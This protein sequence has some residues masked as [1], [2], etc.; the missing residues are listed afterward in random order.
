MKTLRR[1][2]CMHVCYVR[3]HAQ[4]AYR[5]MLKSQ[6]HMHTCACMH[7]QCTQSKRQDDAR[8]A[9]KRIS[10]LITSLHPCSRIR[11]RVFDILVQALMTTLSHWNTVFPDSIVRVLY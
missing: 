4:R 1:C 7:R 9:Q 8:K 2:A 3:K 5:H 6:M 11:Q 10:G